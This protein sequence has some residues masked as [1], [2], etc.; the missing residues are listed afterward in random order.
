MTSLRR[1]LEGYGLTAL[2][3]ADFIA[4]LLFYRIVVLAAIFGIVFILGSVKFYL[5]TKNIKSFSYSFQKGL[6][7]EYYKSK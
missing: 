5:G 7:V 6:K 3:I 4:L 2:F 1:A